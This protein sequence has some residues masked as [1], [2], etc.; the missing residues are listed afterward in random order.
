MKKILVFVSVIILSA[1]GRGGQAFK[2]DLAEAE[3]RQ[4]CFGSGTV[5][6]ETMK[7]D[8]LI[9][10]ANFK[11]GII[12]DNKEKYISACSEDGY[13]EIVEKISKLIEIYEKERPGFFRRT[14]MSESEMSS[15]SRVPNFTNSD[16]DDLVDKI[17]LAHRGKS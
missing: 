3:Y 6:C 4:E 17:C 11:K 2:L 1:C 16:Y 12:E 9:D 13:T 5:K 10:V 7:I 14:F 8:L 15:P